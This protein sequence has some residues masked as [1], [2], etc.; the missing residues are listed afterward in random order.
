MRHN[1]RY[2]TTLI[3]MLSFALGAWAEPTVNIIKQLNGTAN[4][5]AGTASAEIE[6]GWCTLTVTPA[7]G[8]Y[9]TVEFIT[10]YSTVPGSSANIR[11][12]TP[13]LDNTTIDIEPTDDEEPDPSG[14]TTYTFAMPD[15]ESNVDVTINFQSRKSVADL[16]ISDISAQ[17]YTGS[18][19]EPRLT[20]TDGN[21]LLELDTDYSVA[22][23]DNTNAGT[24]TATITGLG[25]YTGTKSKTF[26]IAAQAIKGATVTVDANA[27]LVY[28]GTAKNPGVTVSKTFEGAA[29]Q[30]VFSAETDYD[31][32]YSEGCINVGEYTITVTFKGNY[33]GTATTT[34]NISQAAGSINYAEINVSKTFDD[35]PF[36]NAITNTGDGTVSYSSNNTGVAT[37]NAESGLVTIVGAG[38]ATITATVTDGTN[39]TYDT[40]TATY[41]LSVGKAT[42]KGLTVSIDNWRVGETASTPSVEGNEGNGAVTYTYAAQGTETFSGTKPTTAG[43]YTI[44]VTVA[45]TANYLGGVATAEFTILNRQ[46]TADGLFASGTKY[47]SYYSG[48]ED[49]DLGEG[50]AVHII[51]GVNGTSVTTTPLS[52]IPRGIPV[53]LESITGSPTATESNTTG[54]ML[55]YASEATTVARSTGIA[56]V[57]YNN[58]YVRVTDNAIPAGKTYLLVPATSAAAGAR[59]LSISHGNGTTG[60]E[61]VDASLS[62]DN[63]ERWFDLQGRRIS[64]P[65]KTGIYI[66]DGKKVVIK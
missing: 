48:T 38:E 37:V 33:S 46:L 30:K 27:N 10:A 52:F 45:E 56:Y 60:I 17:T 31:V 63:G 12:R 55:Q 57:L 47:A 65:S 11:T 36:A 26:T 53:L 64:K 32:A 19:I 14:V 2:V 16:T 24:A 40:K 61:S 8:N 4:D 62:S 13:E 29:A 6:D 1:A 34:F 21:N 15:D 9:V 22:Y 35:A 43:S 18:A 7:S 3:I 50:I 44:K 42:M 20:V 58:M 51:T 49:I 28:D 59:Q 39:Y 23:S 66:R 25:T 41:T 54:N 5:A